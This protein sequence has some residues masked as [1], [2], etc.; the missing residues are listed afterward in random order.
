MSVISIIIAIAGGLSS[1][2][3]IVKEILALINKKSNMEEKIGA[4]K[5]LRAALETYRKTGDRRL[6]DIVYSKL[7]PDPKN[8]L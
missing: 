2:I 1:I 4:L 7:Q 3:S 6:L 5:D 8:E